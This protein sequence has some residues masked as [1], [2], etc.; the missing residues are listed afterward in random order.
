MDRLALASTTARVDFSTHALM[1]FP[2]NIL[3]LFA[4]VCTLPEK[5]SPDEPCGSSAN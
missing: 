1:D 4:S 5:T 2:Q 3:F